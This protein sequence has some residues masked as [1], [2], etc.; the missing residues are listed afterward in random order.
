MKLIIHNEGISCW[1]ERGGGSSLLSYTDTGEGTP[2]VFIHG[3]GCRK[4]AW[5]P[6]LELANKH[7]LIIPDLRGHGET[8]LSDKLTIRNFAKDIIKL[9][10]QLNIKSAYICG[11]SLGGIVAQEIHMQR[12]DLVKGLILANTT[13]HISQ[14]FANEMIAKM[15]RLY[16]DGRLLDYISSRGV[17][18]QSYKQHAM[19]AFNIRDTYLIAAKAGIGKNYYPYLSLI[20]K[21]VLLIGSS[22]DRITPVTEMYMMRYYIRNAKL[23]VFDNAGHM[24]NIE[25]PKKFNKLVDE[26]ISENEGK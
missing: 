16:N 20:E 18:D 1:F 12:P 11:L 25:Q 22:Q 9:L 19:N 4:E 13:S 14:M 21:S 17:F 15:T 6:Q 5:N 2:I 3:L 26:F 8:E 10:E 23:F 24:S 7:R